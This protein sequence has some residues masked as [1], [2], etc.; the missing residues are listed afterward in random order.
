MSEFSRWI[1]GGVFLIAGAAAQ[2]QTVTYDFTAAV[3]SSSGLF[4]SLPDGSAVTGTFTIDLAAANPK[5]SFDLGSPTKSGIDE[6]AGGLSVGDAAPQAFVFASTVQ[7]GTVPFSS[8][9]AAAYYTESAVLTEPAKSGG[10]EE[11]Q[12]FEITSTSPGIYVESFIT[13]ASRD[14]FSS[15]GLPNLTGV[16]KGSDTGGFEEDFLGFDSEVNYRLTSIEVAPP[17]TAAPELDAG[18]AGSALT[19]A[20]GSLLVF[21]ARA[22]RAR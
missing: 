19:L 18:S 8:G 9:S 22:R 6:T 11:Y 14:A 5:Q 1:V 3:T 13:L 21:G 16:A 10:P 20:L 12:G 17:A 15:N 7:T 4:A 2:A